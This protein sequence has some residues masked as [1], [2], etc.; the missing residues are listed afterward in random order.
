MKTLDAT[1]ESVQ[2][3]T[4]RRPVIKI[5]SC[6]TEA[7][8]PF[9]GDVF[10][11][12]T[13][14]EKNPDARTHSS[15]R[16]VV[17]YMVGPGSDGKYHIRY[18][19]SDTERTYFSCVEFET[20]YPVGNHVSLCEMADGN[21]CLIWD[22]V[23][24][25]TRS[26]KYRIITAL[27]ANLDP[28]STGTIFSQ[29]SSIEYTGAFISKMVDGSYLMVYSLFVSA[30]SHYHLY[31]RTSSD[32][33]TWSAASEIPT[34]GLTDAQKKSNPSLLVMAS[35]VWIL[36]DV[37]DEIGPSGEE[38]KNVYYMESTDKFA[39]AGV[40]TALT[41]YDTYDM[42]GEHPYA[43][44]KTATD[45]YL[46]FDKLISALH[47]DSGTDGWGIGTTGAIGNMHF[48][49]TGQ[50]L[51][52]MVEQ[53]GG[54]AKVFYGVIKI[55]VPTWTIDKF[56]NTTST[57][58][59][60]SIFTLTGAMWWD[61][62]HGEGDYVPVANEVGVIQLLNGE[63][64]TITTY[65]FYSHGS[66]GIAKNVDWEPVSKEGASFISDMK[67]SKVWVDVSSMR[68]YVALIRTYIYNTALQ[69]GYFDLTDSAETKT[70]VSIV[71]ES[72]TFEEEVLY[73][74]F[75]MENG[76]MII[77]P[78]LSQIIVGMGQ[79]LT[80]SD[81]KGCL[82]IFDLNDGGTWKSY[83]PD[84]DP[85]FPY[86]GVSR[87]AYN[88]AT[89]L[90]MCT[91]PYESLYGNADR[92]GLCAIDTVNDIILYY[93]PSYASVNDYGLENIILTSEGEYIVGSNG[94][95]IA[96]FN[97]STW[98]LTSND[99]LPGLTSSAEEMWIGPIVYDETNRMIITGHGNG[100]TAEWSGLVMFS[101]DGYLKQS[102]YM[103]G[104]YS[105]GVWT[106]GAEDNLV[107]GWTDFGAAICVD[108]DDS[109]LYGF[110]DNLA[111]TEH[112][113]KWDKEQPAFNVIKY[114][115]AGS[116]IELVSIIDPETGNWDS[117]IRFSVSH[118]HLF[119]TS[120]SSSL[121][122]AYMRKGRKIQ[123]QFGE[124]VSGVEYYEPIQVFTISNDGEVIYKRGSYPT[125]EITAE[126]PRRR[127]ND[128]H[129]D[130]TEYYNSYPELI[131]EDLLNTFLSIPSSSCSLG[132]WDNRAV[133]EYQWVDVSLAD[134]IDQLAYHFGY[135]IRT[136]ANGN[137]EAIKITNSADPVITYSNNDLIERV[138]PKNGSSSWTNRWIVQS[139]EK[140]F[141]ELI[142]AE[143]LAAE[144]NASH[145]WNT[146]EK[147]YKVNYTQGNKIFRNPRLEM[148]ESVKS[149]GFQLAGGCD[150]ELLDDSHDEDDQTKW[151][152]FCHVNVSS[153]DLT[154]AFIAFLAA[155]IVEAM[156]PDFVEAVGFIE[157]VGITIPYGR[158]IYNVTLII[159]LQILASTGNFHYRIYGQP[160]T[161]VRRQIYAES[162]DTALQTLMGQIISSQPYD[163]PLC[164]T[165]TEC[166]MV[167]DYLKMVGMGERS[168]WYCEKV[169]DL[170]IQEGDTISVLHPMSLDPVKVFITDMTLVF[171]M[172][173][174]ADD[175]GIY[176]QKIEGWRR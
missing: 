82:Y 2:T 5:D 20:G 68:M 145:R 151:D 137:I 124:K 45:I 79:S 66:Y 59:F 87:G 174:D 71:E 118:G 122:R 52:I 10:S 135:A 156:I 63:A 28:A 149:L 133:L 164:S 6:E 128:V 47:M 44:Q 72:M 97:G 73:G 116:D 123:V 58:A 41:S 121:L 70:F 95:G 134:A 119:D 91:F 129:I 78:S 114:L 100:Y 25:G 46:A 31:R 161:K 108:P 104:A 84:S 142:L 113:T 136:G 150:E 143:E 62:Y 130:A 86:R 171:T 64:D 155:L 51:Y 17:A 165:V 80:V 173:E 117:E 69:I 61:A 107:A 33:I 166:Q 176:S 140:T 55:D 88:P 152:T 12:T 146:G 22:E 105:G 160:V 54:G 77:E 67:I 9:V 90:L 98:E 43:I 110:W 11:T 85:T 138:T 36:F 21:I 158:V 111:G 169:P 3:L 27:G 81:W 99:S 89:G 139:E 153:P 7:S 154:I 126:T 29:S 60:N 13:I 94:Y 101:R 23:Y 32:C 96:I 19:Y 42:T 18:G 40:A 53:M 162:N 168:R 83:D 141:Q 65:A 38:L 106:F 26:T 112:S 167:A 14:N 175:S 127:W 172:P 157:N 76:F 131:I 1:L 37:V 92:R 125:M 16:L 93:R 57:P 163:D 102:T 170:R 159:C 24:S 75:D 4:N 30:D 49:S 115:L 144:F 35:S 147:T 50:K 15:G 56:W 103:I 148:V 8:I 34:S 109:G 39:T 132:T 120:N 48:D 74:G